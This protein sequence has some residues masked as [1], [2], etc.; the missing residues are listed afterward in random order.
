MPALRRVPR[1]GEALEVLIGDGL[2][3]KL[4]DRV[5]V[6]RASVRFRQLA[7]V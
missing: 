2:G 3:T 4:G 1:A 6:L 7:P 5:G